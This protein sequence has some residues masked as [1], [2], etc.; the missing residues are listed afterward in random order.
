[1]SRQ[2]N[3]LLS[4]IQRPAIATASLSH[5]GLTSLEQTLP[6]ESLAQQKLDI[7]LRPLFGGER[8]QEHH[9]FLEIHALEL[10]RPLHQEGCTDVEV[11]F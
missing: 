3:S 6:D 7:L 4:E 8:L 5:M 10:I 9:D 2:Q 11:E 1:M